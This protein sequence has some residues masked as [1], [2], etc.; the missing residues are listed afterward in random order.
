MQLPH[1]GKFVNKANAQPNCNGACLSTIAEATA[2][3]LSKSSVAS[4]A[5]ATIAGIVTSPD[6]T[7]SSRNAAVLMLLNF[8]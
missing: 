1:S 6:A 3:Y 2:L 8:R 5:A 4:L 7:L